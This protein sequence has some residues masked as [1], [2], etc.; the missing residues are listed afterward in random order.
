MMGGRGAPPWT[1]YRYLEKDF[2]IVPVPFDVKA[3]EPGDKEHPF[4][5][6]DLL[7]IVHPV[8]INRPQSPQPGMPP[9]GATTIEE[10]SA[11]S[12]D[13]VD[14]FIVNGGKV[15]AFLDNQYMVSRY[16]DPYST[17]LPFQPG[18]DNP[19][20][21]KELTSLFE[22]ER[23]PSYRSGLDELYRSWG[24]RV[25]GAGTQSPVLVDPTYTRPVSYPRPVQ[26]ILRSEFRLV[27][28]LRKIPDQRWTQ[29]VVE[30]ME[31]G[32]AL[33][34]DFSGDALNKDSTV[35]RNLGSVR[36][37]DPGPIEGRP[38]SGLTMRTLVNASKKAKA[39][40]G[41]QVGFLLNVSR[42]LEEAITRII[43][44]PASFAS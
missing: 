26:N 1:I 44:I 20:W 18:A 10:L 3:M 6:L 14:Q 39:L 31:K 30:S 15:L 37:V 43:G 35:T 41:D 42:S 13:A 28:Q 32:A 21:L 29:A 9:M 27:N 25:G 11:E 36:M 8:Q 12:Q 5:D 33:M 38:A 4:H 22:T 2:D 17:V 23:M 34:A 40:P 19:A 24:V 16:F 7:L